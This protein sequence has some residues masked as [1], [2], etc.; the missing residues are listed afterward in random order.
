[1]PNHFHGTIN[2]K[3]AI[4]ALETRTVCV[5]TAH[6]SYIPPWPYFDPATGAEAGGTCSLGL[7]IRLKRNTRTSPVEQLLNPD[8]L[9]RPMIKEL[10]RQIDWEAR[11]LDRRR[12]LA[13]G[14][15]ADPPPEFI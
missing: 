2:F 8:L 15:P 9:S 13:A 12:R 4:R 14:L 11:L 10:R 3:L 5:A 1:M 6:Y 7:T